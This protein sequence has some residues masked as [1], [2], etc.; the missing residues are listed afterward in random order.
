MNEYELTGRTRTHIEQFS[1]P[2]FAAQHEAGEAFL[3]MREDARRAGFEL[4]PFSTF[5]DF[6]TQLRIWNHKF[7][8][9]KPLYDRDG[10]VREFSTLSPEQVVDHILNWSALPGGS[11]HQWGTEIDVV[12]GSALSSGYA[13]QLLPQEVAPGGI[14]EAL[15]HWLDENIGKYGFFRP[16]KRF[17]GGMYP[18]PWHLSYAPLSMPALQQVSVEI[19]TGAIREADMLGKDIALARIQ[20]IYRN[21]VCNIVL[22]DDQ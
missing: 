2:R 19:L 1:A 5:R 11:R 16:Y 20:D 10:K 12:D 15:H 4:H 9:K 3:A 7:I 6:G 14:F 21:H 17:Q 18:E 22:P 13:P 8:G